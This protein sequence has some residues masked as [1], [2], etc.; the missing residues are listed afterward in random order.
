MVT[1]VGFEPT[2]PKRAY[3][4]QAVKQRS[5]ENDIIARLESKMK[6]KTKQAPENYIME[7]YIYRI[8]KM[9]QEPSY[10]EMF[11]IG[12]GSLDSEKVMGLNQLLEELVPKEKAFKIQM[13]IGIIEILRRWKTKSNIRVFSTQNVLKP[14]DNLAVE[15]RVRNL[16]PTSTTNFLHVVNV[17]NYIEILK[18]PP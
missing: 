3:Q 6:E 14:L 7:P 4:K 18:I 2:P 15:M 12:L 8:N 9:L 13:L 5:M 17:K 10:R 11:R 1:E 16:I